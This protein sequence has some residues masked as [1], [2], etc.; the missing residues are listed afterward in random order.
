MKVVTNREIGERERVDG[1]DYRGCKFKNCELQYFGGE[2]PRFDA[3]CTFDEFCR[4]ELGDE[5]INTMNFLKML[6]QCGTH[7]RAMVRELL[8]EIDPNIRF[9]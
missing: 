8:M 9:K 1:K 2:V 5:A 4:W 3:D 6:Y 7:R